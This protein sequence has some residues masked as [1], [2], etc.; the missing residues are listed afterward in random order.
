MRGLLQGL[1]LEVVRD[2]SPALPNGAAKELPNAAIKLEWFHIVQIF[3][4]LVDA[5][6]KLEGKEEPLPNDLRWAVL[7]RNQLGHLTDNQVLALA[8][9]VDQGC[10]RRRPGESRESW[11]G[12]AAQRHRVRRAGASRTA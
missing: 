12:C 2:T 8:E 3:T 4:G 1:I 5:V 6:R 7:K 10:I 9:I 11:R